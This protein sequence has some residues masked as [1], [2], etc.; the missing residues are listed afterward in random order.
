MIEVTTTRTLAADPAPPPTGNTRL[1]YHYHPSNKAYLGSAENPAQSL[2]VE[3]SPG[4]FAD[5][6][7]TTPLPPPIAPDGQ[8]PVWNGSAWELA[9]D[10]R[11]K[12]LY[13]TTTGA[14]IQR[15][16]VGP[17]PDGMTDIASP[18]PDAVWIGTGWSVPGTPFDKW[19]GAQWVTDLNAMRDAQMD[20]LRF[21]RNLVLA[22]CDWTQ[23]A[24]AP[25]TEAQKMEWR[26]YRKALRDFPASVK[27]PTTAEWPKPPA[28]APTLA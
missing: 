23:V 20:D 4:V 10:H 27:D 1:V 19:N 26:A 3:S 22:S 8:V 11:G 18:S 24:D 21:R 9:E 7:Q 13:S 17:I 5:P 28:G 2:S 6:P 16:G 14:H 25:F 12:A 15:G